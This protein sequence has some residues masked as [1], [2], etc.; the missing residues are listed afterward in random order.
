M[1]T[2]KSNQS[3]P[4][5]IFNT[6]EYKEQLATCLD[7]CDIDQMSPTEQW[8]CVKRQMI[9]AAEG[10]RNVMMRTPI[11]DNSN[12][13]IEARCM[14]LRAIARAVWRQDRRLAKRLLERTAAGPVHLRLE[15]TAVVL[16]DAARFEA[17]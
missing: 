13:D 12:N 4:S 15:D 2:D 10:A 9:L 8:E 7:A 6:K 14:A 3:I 17:E 1:E 11:G 16:R 5:F